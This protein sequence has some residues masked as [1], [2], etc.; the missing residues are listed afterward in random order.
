MGATFMSANCVSAAWIVAAAAGEGADG[1][2]LA[3]FYFLA[4]CWHCR[5]R[6]LGL[7][8]GDF[9]IYKSDLS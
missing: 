6:Y 3:A 7:V 8:V 9:R 5:R 4:R 1:E 2:R